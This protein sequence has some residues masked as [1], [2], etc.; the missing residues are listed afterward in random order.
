MLNSAPRG[1]RAGLSL[2]ELLVALSLLA[3]IA[4]GLAGAFGVGVQVFDR[5]QDL[6]THHEEL[7]ARRQLR[8]ALA[9]ALP[10]SRITPFPNSFLGTADSM[11]FTSLQET[12]FASQASALRIEVFWTASTLAMT[13]DAI[14]DDGT[15]QDRWD[16][17]L[18]RNITDVAF[19]YLD[20]SGD[21]AR[22]QS[23]WNG[24]AD[25]PALIRITGTGG[26]PEWVDF[27]V[28]PRL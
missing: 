21:T 20:S 18:S 16:H 6:D 3:L 13:V 9:Q 2:L 5:A 19:S 27:V 10:A 25:L 23:I 7:S 11:T 24:R 22:W 15:V 17:V 14:A 1:S 12:P 8:S 26:A 4:A 28:G